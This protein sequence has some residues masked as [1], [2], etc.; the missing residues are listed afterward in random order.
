MVV[1]ING[2]P[3]QLFIFIFEFKLDS[4]ASTALQQTKDKAYAEKYRLRGKNITLVG[5][6]FNYKERK[7]TEWKSVSDQP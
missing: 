1:I 7:I 4:K 2:T 3:I 5:T 6:N